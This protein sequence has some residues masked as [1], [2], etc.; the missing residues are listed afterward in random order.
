MYQKD[1]TLYTRRR[2]CSHRGLVEAKADEGQTL[3]VYPTRIE[4]RAAQSCRMQ[5][6]AKLC[7]SAHT[8]LSHG[9]RCEPHL[10]ARAE[11]D[12]V[13]ERPAAQERRMKGWLRRAAAP[14]VR[15]QQ[16]DTHAQRTNRVWMRPE[17]IAQRVSS[18]G[19]LCAL[20]PSDAG[21][22]HT[23]T[24]IVVCYTRGRVMWCGVDGRSEG[25]HSDGSWYCGISVAGP[26]DAALC[27]VQSGVHVVPQHD[28]LTSARSR[29][30]S[31]I[32]TA[33]AQ[34]HGSD[35]QVRL[36][37]DTLVRRT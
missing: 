31:E 29:S 30:L 10:A 14:F 33:A 20:D 19:K 24:N 21:R 32:H 18:R 7:T 36:A 26:V 17:R 1:T 5:S 23:R 3:N 9:S 16:G 11:G 4:L 6:R 37:S 12:R 35:S 34:V 2:S 28:K 15:A 8:R 22:R 13:I 25:P 27:A